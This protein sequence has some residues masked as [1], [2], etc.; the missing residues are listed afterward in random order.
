MIIH[1]KCYSQALQES[2]IFGAKLVEIHTLL[3][4]KKDRITLL[5]AHMTR[6]DRH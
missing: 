2:A 5:F 1:I 4:Y 3:N 6:C